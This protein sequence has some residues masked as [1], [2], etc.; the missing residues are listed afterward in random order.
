MKV[1]RELYTGN[2]KRYIAIP[3]ILLVLSVFL[4]F[5]FP[6]VPTGIDLSGGTLIIIRSNQ[7]LD[8]QETK[9]LLSDN[10][11]LTD[12]SVVSTSS[13]LGGNGLTIKFAQNIDIVN[14]EA[15]LSLAE[16]SIES[17]PETARQHAQ[18]TVNIL[19]SYVEPVEL[20]SD[21]ATAVQQASELLVD[22]KESFNNRVQQLVV[23]HF[24]LKGDVAFQKKEVSPT[25]GKAFYET[26]FN[27]AIF[28]M[29][30]VAIVIFLFFRK[31]VPSL[32][33]I[34]SAFLDV[35]GALALMAIFRIPLTLSS[36]PALLMLVG[37]SV[38]TDVMLTTKLLQ[39]KE[40]VVHERVYDAMITGLT[41][42]ATTI[43]ALF[44]MLTLSFF[45]Q[46]LVIYEIAI[47]L[48]FGLVIDISSTWF[49]N[50]PVL[51]WY[52]EKQRKKI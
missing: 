34:A 44:A 52:L 46:M 19:E 45:A 37:Y 1:L 14:A 48:L 23:E 40:G 39:R 21:P 51:L 5:V 49:M 7:P 6:G 3:L 42:N 30:L 25:L 2:Y 8:A 9:Q 12:L 26:T 22:A 17:T 31:V 24:D 27:V 20:E 43:A 50:A 13:P 29:I 47:V 33:V 18:N 15:E 16:S 11:E 35:L 41:M 38:D 32:A 10:F 28:A 36:I 4:A